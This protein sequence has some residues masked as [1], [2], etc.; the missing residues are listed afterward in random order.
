MILLSLIR[1]RRKPRKRT[2][3]AE[4]EWAEENPMFR[5]MTDAEMA[6]RKIRQHAMKLAYEGKSHG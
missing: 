4:A 1:Q 6:A 3:G 5:L 2:P